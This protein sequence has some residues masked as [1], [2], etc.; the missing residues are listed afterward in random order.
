VPVN[1]RDKLLALIERYEELGTSKAEGTEQQRSVI[2]HALQR[3]PNLLNERKIALFLANEVGPKDMTELEWQSPHQMMQF[4]E[5]LYL[6][7]FRESDNVDQLNQHASLLIRRALYQ[8]E[9]KGEMEE[10]IELLRLTPSFL[11]REDNEL[12]RLHYRVNVY[13]TRRVRRARRYLFAY[14]IAQVILVLIVFPFLF[15]NAENG[16]LQS[17]VEELADVEIGD[18]GYQL[19]TFPEGVYWAV[20]TASSIG[21]GDITPTTT[22]GKVIAATLGTMGVITVAIIAGLILQWITPRRLT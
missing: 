22:T 8:L 21:Y 18:E 17:Q 19:I 4:S 2:L 3:E 11:L 14:L 12:S 16:K 20:I 15:I 10:M 6:T 7:R 1:S 9:E 13:E 5:S